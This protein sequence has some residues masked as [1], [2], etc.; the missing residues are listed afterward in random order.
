MGKILVLQHHRVETPGTIG[1]ALAGAGLSWDSVRTFDGEPVPRDLAGADGLV[2]MGGP[3][4]VY[5][6]DRFAF[7]RDE[8]ALIRSA[9]RD[10]KPVLGVC[11]GS[12]LLA[13]ALDANVRPGRAKELG[14][15]PVRLSSEAKEDCLMRGVPETFTAFHWHGDVFDRPRGAVALASSATTPIQAF[16]YGESAYGFLF[17]M[18]VTADAV[19]AMVREFSDEARQAGADS[20]GIIAAT[21]RHMAELSPISAAVFSRWAGLFSA[22]QP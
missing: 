2:V 4:G 1:S 12:Q 9:I 16:R 21:A 18:E 15:H 17:H 20:D 10:E 5:E 6:T 14:W 8:I 19:A 11:L 7:I 13:A 3:M 22:P